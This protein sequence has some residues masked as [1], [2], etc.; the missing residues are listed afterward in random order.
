MLTDLV[1]RGAGSGRRR[2]GSR[3]WVPIAT[4]VT[5][6][7]D[8]GGH[9]DNRP[10]AALL[11]VTDRAARWGGARSR[12]PPPAPGSGPRAAPRHASRRRLGLRARGGLRAHRV[13][14]PGRGGVRPLGGRPAAP[15]PEPSISDVAMAAAADMFELGVKVQVLRRGHAL[16]GPR[17]T[18]S[19]TS[20]A[21]T[22]RSR[23]SRAR[24]P[25]ASSRQDPRRL[26]RG[27]LEGDGSL[28]AASRSRARRPRRRG[29]EAPHGAGVPLVPRQ[30]EPVGD[31]RRDAPAHADYQVWCGPA[32]GAFNDWARGSF[33]EDP[34]ARTV[35]QIGLNL[36]EGA[37]VIGRAQALR[38][39][40]RRAVP[41]EAFA[42]PPPRRLSLG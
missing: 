29:P 4:D 3:P 10:L 14:Q 22:L 20:I 21:R 2:R 37:A 34:S 38:D 11:P 17:P 32:M 31:R 25:R 24:R 7:A 35:G 23:R 13:R 6:E 42:L 16:R 30:V 41:A 1:A 9:T 40:R 27:R 26:D 8:S 19:T 33:L 12:P 15:R 39:L 36:L 28:L 18:G 5:V